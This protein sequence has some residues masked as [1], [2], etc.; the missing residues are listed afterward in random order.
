MVGIESHGFFLVNVL[1]GLDG[2]NEIE[3]VLV[4]GSGNQYGVNGFV[5]EQAAKIGQCPNSG[6]EL[7]G[8]LQAAS[9]NVGN[10][11]GLGIRCT[12]RVL[13]NVESASSGADQPE[14]DAV[15]SAEDT[16]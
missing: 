4:L 12:E 7:L 14:A 5:I 9:I 10:R 8:F 6:R 16:R 13:E 3:S 2:G 15:I 1:A 11:N